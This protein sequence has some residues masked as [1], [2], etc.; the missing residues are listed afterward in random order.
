M[1]GKYFYGLGKRKSSVARVRVY[2]GKGDVLINGSKDIKLIKHIAFSPFE[3][4]GLD[5]KSYDV[6]VVVNGGG[7]SGQ[8]QAMR[9]GISRALVEMDKS[10]RGPLKLAGFLKRDPR[11]VERKKAGLTKARRAPQWRKR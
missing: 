5:R 11:R 1:K 6:S 7:I 10:V 8:S 4:A 9:H 2:E 3:T